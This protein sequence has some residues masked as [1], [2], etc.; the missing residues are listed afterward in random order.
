MQG[1]IVPDLYKPCIETWQARGCVSM[2]KSWYF[3]LQMNEHSLN[4]EIFLET[5]VLY[6]LDT[7][8]FLINKFKK[9][10]M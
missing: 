2:G 4:P 10:V 6:I 3:F 9:I 1:G 5:L 7:A 8:V